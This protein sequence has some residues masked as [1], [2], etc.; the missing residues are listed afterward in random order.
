[1]IATEGDNI[2]LDD[3]IQWLTQDPAT[4]LWSG[5]TTQ[6]AA[7]LNEDFRH[8]SDTD[9]NKVW[10]IVWGE[11]ETVAKNQGRG[12]DPNDDDTFWEGLWDDHHRA[13]PDSGRL[14]QLKKESWSDMIVRTPESMAPVRTVP[15]YA[16][17]EVT[18]DDRRQRNGLLLAKWNELAQ[19]IVIDPLYDPV[20]NVQYKND[21]QAVFDLWIALTGGRR[22][23]ACT[24]AS[25]QAVIDAQ[26]E[27]ERQLHALEGVEDVR[28]RANNAVAA[29][30]A[31]YQNGDE[32]ATVIASGDTAYGTPV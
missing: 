30:E 10:G 20:L 17:M 5:N 13:L 24:A 14:N 7:W 8:D 21:Q 6:I 25:V 16:P 12:P 3:I 15:V 2:R 1:M 31:S 4:R 23:G 22:F 26:N 32:K 28:T 19:E 9:V 18:P 27:I 29:A 11:L